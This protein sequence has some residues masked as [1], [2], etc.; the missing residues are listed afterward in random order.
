MPPQFKDFNK[1]VKDLLTKNHVALGEWK[2][3]SKFKGPDAQLY[4]NPQVVKGHMTVDL[5]FGMK[6]HGAKAKVSVGQSKLLEQA[7]VTWEKQGHKVEATTKGELTYELQRGQFAMLDKLTKSRLEAAASWQCCSP[8]VLGASAAYD[9]QSNA[10]AAYAVGFRYVQAP[11]TVNVTA[12]LKEKKF[13]TG[14]VI[15]IEKVKTAIQADCKVSG[16]AT[17]TAG[18]Q[19]TCPF[20]NVI[21]VKATKL[22]NHAVE[23][24]VNILRKFADGWK[25][26]LTLTTKDYKK[27]GVYVV[28]E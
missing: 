27:I 11:Y 24:S 8:A 15:P 9:Y 7:V 23:A 13:T 22:P 20:G 10:L 1:D 25:A 6:E 4:I 2:L 26:A 3:E 5:E 19:F 16:E 18:A 28:R 17:V 21:T 12:D 14:A